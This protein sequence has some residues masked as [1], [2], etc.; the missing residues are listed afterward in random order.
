MFSSTYFSELGVAPAYVGTTRSLSKAPWSFD[1]FF[2]FKV[3][4]NLHISDPLRS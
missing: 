3:K 4:G 1:S 2:P